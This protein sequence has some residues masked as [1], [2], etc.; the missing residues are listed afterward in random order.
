MTILSIRDDKYPHLVFINEQGP[1]E[2]NSGFIY[3]LL[4]ESAFVRINSRGMQSVSME[5]E[6][7]ILDSSK[8]KKAWCTPT[9][10]ALC[11]FEK[12]NTKMMV[13]PSGQVDIPDNFDSLTI[14]G[15]EYLD[16]MNGPPCTYMHSNRLIVKN[17]AEYEISL[18]DLLNGNLDMIVTK[19]QI[20]WR[21]D[22]TSTFEYVIFSILGI[23]LVSLLTS[24]M[25]NILNR[26]VASKKQ[27][28]IYALLLI[29]TSIYLT[30]QTYTNTNLFLPTKQ[31]KGVAG[32]L[33]VF[34]WTQLI[35]HYKETFV[36]IFRH[37]FKCIRINRDPAS[38][39]SKQDLEEC[40]QEQSISLI[41][42]ILLLLILQIYY[43]IDTPYNTVMT[44]LFLAR[45]WHKLQTTN[46]PVK[47]ESTEYLFPLKLIFFLW[48]RL[49]D[50]YVS[51][52]LLLVFYKKPPHLLFSQM[53]ILAVLMASLVLSVCMLFMNK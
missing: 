38:A 33:V 22:T 35:Q 27:S 13:F 36:K 50:L 7:N 5:P 40:T 9:E 16:S 47:N 48:C 1:Y 31:D 17:D 15:H 8:W 41:I 45:S 20:F 23:Y 6:N 10:S 32:V 46:P 42:S 30:I 29:L 12:G 51:V 3:S 2:W 4:L 53:H 49:F 28:W 43:S 52:T 34:I 11:R 37:F 19:T 39:D 21:Q 25:A 26:D 14:N 44:T 24:N 18:C